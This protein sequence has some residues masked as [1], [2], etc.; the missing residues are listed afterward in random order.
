M[1][2]RHPSAPLIHSRRATHPGLILAYAAALVCCGIALVSPS[3]PTLS[4]PTW[5]PRVSRVPAGVVP[6]RHNL[7]APRAGRWIARQSTMDKFKDMVT[8][9]PSSFTMMVPDIVLKGADRVQGFYS[10][11]ND[12][13]GA[14]KKIPDLSHMKSNGVNAL[15]F[16]KKDLDFVGK[17]IS[18]LFDQDHPI[19]RAVTEYFFRAGGKRIRPVMVLIM[20]RAILAHTEAE[21]AALN[22]ESTVS[23]SF[24]THTIP[25]QVQL[26]QITELIHTASLFHDDIID[27]SDTRRGQKTVN[28]AYGNRVAVLSGDFLLARSAILLAELEDPRVISGMATSIEHLCGGELLQIKSTKNDLATFAYY[29]EKTFYKTGSLMAYACQSAAQLAGADDEIIEAAYQYGGYLGIAFQIVDDLLDFQQSES[30]TGKPVGVDM[31]NG[32]ATAPVLYA[33]EEFPELRELILR[34]FK[35]EGDAEK[36][37]AMVQESTGIEKTQRLVE[38]YQKKA[39]EAASKFQNSDAREALVN[40]AELVVARKS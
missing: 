29:I 19:L 37:L 11:I 3:H 28:S 5:Q 21:K 24:D 2:A 30:T 9:V 40:L 25:T 23:T 14:L 32:H 12:V 15:Q 16:I 35:N 26:A 13:E 31:Q 22:K 18:S 1:P 8:R 10:E 33:M 20:A 39:L 7:K 38:Y 36:G 4:T 34:R 17:R 6:A 27:V